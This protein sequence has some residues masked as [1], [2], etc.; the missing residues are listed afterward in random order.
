VIRT[1]QKVTVV[2]GLPGSFTG[3]AF[4]AC[5]TPSQRQMDVWR[6]ESPYTGVGF[7]FS[8][9]NRSCSSQ[10]HLDAD[11]VA[12]QAE[13]GWRLL[14][15]T[16]GRQAA[17]SALHVT[18]VDDDP[19]GSYAAARN[20][21]EVEA[22]DAVQA[23]HDL[24]IGTRSVLW[25]DVEAF[26]TGTTDCRSSVLAYV[27]GWTSALH[28]R[29]Y[30]SGVYS[31]AASGMRMLDEARR[32]GVD[33]LP[34]LVWYADWN[35]RADTRSRHLAVTGWDGHRRVHQFF[36][37]RTETYGGVSLEIDG[38][39]M[40]TGRGSVAPPEGRHCG[41]R[42]D[43]GRYPA[44]SAGSHGPAVAAL[45]CFLRGQGFATPVDA[46][47]AGATVAAVRAL[48]D[49]HGLPVTGTVGT[50]DWVV[51]LAGGST[52][53]VKYGSASD[54]VRRLQ[55]ALT[56]AGR[57]VPVTGAFAARTAKAV[58]RYQASVGREPT[59]VVTPDLWVLL[60]RGTTRRPH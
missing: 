2:H 17:C 9:D 15:I 53:L 47:F 51:L 19:Q 27:A 8:G 25:L 56:A 7:Y 24:G 32:G 39:F 23:A 21:G 55:R 45:Q 34:D 12:T 41:V 5:Q 16:V 42:V 20:Q 4:D 22:D 46:R 33:G 43:L 40:D 1:Q 28:E 13:R 57:P 35:G 58:R 49:K 60:Q 30:R 36:G 59:G 14:P 48:Q 54:A 50:T 37:N 38:D 44:L 52:P 3:L 26:D 11:W 10:P 6:T 18:K 31:S 29:H